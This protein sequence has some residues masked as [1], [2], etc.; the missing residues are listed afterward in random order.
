[1]RVFRKEHP[2][3]WANFYLENRRALLACATAWCGN[4]DDAADLIQE[5]ILRQLGRKEVPENARA[6]VLRC[7][8]NLAIDRR[9]AAKSAEPLTVDAAA[10]IADTTIDLDARGVREHLI[11]AVEQLPIQQ[12]E[13]VLL[14]AVA[15][16]TIAETAAVLDKPAGSIASAYARGIEELQRILN[17]ELIDERRESGKRPRQHLNR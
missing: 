2:P 15:G 7:I 6:F 9:R 1:M 10:A 3:D 17:P 14:R 4:V 12:R 8:R 5:A 13:A 16:L 11:F